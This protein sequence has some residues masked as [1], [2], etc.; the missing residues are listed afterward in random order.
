MNAM[1]K[2]H[3]AILERFAKEAREHAKRLRL[4]ADH[5]GQREVTVKQAET[6]E[7]S[8]KSYEMMIA[9]AKKAWT[10]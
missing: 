3:I 2:R 9:H 4:L 8:A 10:K 6:E 1:Q 7:L 5:L